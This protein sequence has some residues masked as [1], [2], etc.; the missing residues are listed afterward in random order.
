MIAITGTELAILI[1]LTRS[2][3]PHSTRRLKANVHTNHGFRVR[4]RDLRSLEVAGCVTLAD[5]KTVTIT[6]VG[7]AE[8]DARG[9]VL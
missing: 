5:R 1:E 2:G 8:V 6:E 7:R 9:G 3:V 4:R